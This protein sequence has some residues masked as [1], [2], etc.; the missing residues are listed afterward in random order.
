MCVGNDQRPAVESPSSATSGTIFDGFQKPACAELL[1]WT[2]LAHDA[3]KGWAKIAFE[4]LPAF[5]NPAG[6]V[7]GGLLTAMLDDSMGPALLLMTEGKSY[8][9][10][11]D[12]HVSFLAPARP[13]RLIG[14]GQV[15]QLG[16]TIAFLEGLLRDGEGTLI[17]RAISNARVVPVGNLPGKSRER[18]QAKTVAR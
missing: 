16:K 13:G 3:A 18:S 9:V 15:L 4:G 11:I 7:Q 14:E 10:T 1:G 17:A 2:L 6:F 8:S 12:M 5:L